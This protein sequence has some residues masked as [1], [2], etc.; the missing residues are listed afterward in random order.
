LSSPKIW[1]LA[2]SGCLLGGGL[3]GWLQPTPT[4]ITFLSVGQGDCAV[5]QSQGRTVLVDAGPKSAH[6]DAGERLIL[7]KLRQMGVDRVDLILLSHPDMDHIG[8]TPSLLRSFPDARIVVSAQFMNDPEMVAHIATL[9]IPTDKIAWIGPE[10]SGQIGDLQ[11][12]LACPP[13]FSTR[14][15]NNGS[16]FVRVGRG[17][18]EAVFSGDAPI[19]VENQMGQRGD[20]SAE[21]MKAGHHG[22][23]TATGPAWLR[24]VHPEYV[25]ISCGRDNSYGHPHKEALDRITATGAKVARTDRDGDVAFELQGN[26]FVRVTP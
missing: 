12:R 25:V 4:R 14:E 13:L 17:A 20:W 9:K 21:V 26:R 1:W 24:T 22:S 7:P 16:M 5:I 10:S 19:A 18:A 15:D 2:G 8:G 6:F 11:L 23:R 3:F